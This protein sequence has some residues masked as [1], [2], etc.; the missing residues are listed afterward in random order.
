MG[1]KIV[2]TNSQGKKSHAVLVP[3]VN[4]V[5]IL[6]QAIQRGKACFKVVGLTGGQR[7]GH[8]GQNSCCIFAVCSVAN[9]GR[10][11]RGRLKDAGL[12]TSDNG[13]KFV[14]LLPFIA[15]SLVVNFIG[16]G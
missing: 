1:S 6:G 2:F 8:K 10:Q 13:N 3:R 7:S 4:V 5:H 15:D 12:I 11:M 9:T 16:K 14:K